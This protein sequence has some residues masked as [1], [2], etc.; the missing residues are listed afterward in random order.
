MPGSRAPCLA[1]RK[2]ESATQR[3]LDMTTPV[4]E[5]NPPGDDKAKPWNEPTP[6]PVPLGSDRPPTPLWRRY[7]ALAGLGVAMILIA[8]WGILQLTHAVS[9]QKHY[10]ENRNAERA[11]QEYVQEPIDPESRTLAAQPPPE[12]VISTRDAT[13]R[14]AVLKMQSDV[15]AAQDLLARVLMQQEQWQELAPPLLGN[16]EGRR[17]A[18][19]PGAV[20]LFSLAQDRERLTPR[21]AEGIRQSLL[22]IATPVEAAA[23]DEATLLNLDPGFT[24]QLTTIRDQL[25]S[26]LRQWQEDN[27]LVGLLVS[28]AEQRAPA[29]DTLA[30]AVK[31]LRATELRLRAEKI[32]ADVAAAESRLAAEEADSQIR[33][34]ELATQ[35]KLASDEVEAKRR[36]AKVANLDAEKLALADQLAAERARAELERKF[37]ADLPEIRS[38]LVPF[39]TP[40]NQ[41]IIKGRW[42]TVEEKQPVSWSGLQGSRAMRNEG[43]SDQAMYFLGGGRDNDRPNGPFGSYIGGHLSPTQATL[44]LKAQRLL[45]TYGDLMVEKKMLAP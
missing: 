27:A 25:K 13:R 30:E 19:D 36:E 10:A 7:L 20:K 26:G 40:G 4:T 12:K 32:A 34:Q 41:Q 17:I 8:G 1:S 43:T 45:R 18:A 42:T 29:D 38:V 31:T 44:V 21:A 33:L 14:L 35:E 28:E 23:A 37:Q 16:E 22:A 2:I 6:Q 15:Q 3:T 24:Q 11:G 5:E 9:N 39:I